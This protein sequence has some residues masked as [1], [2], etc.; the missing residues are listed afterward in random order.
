MTA[1]GLD[2]CPEQPTLLRPEKESL[3]TSAA[4]SFRRSLG[5]FHVA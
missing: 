1:S 5:R 2:L 4:G 3:S